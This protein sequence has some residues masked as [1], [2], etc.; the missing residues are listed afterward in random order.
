MIYLI[1]LN[2]FFSKVASKNITLEMSS[3]FDIDIDSQDENGVTMLME[4]IEFGEEQIV[5]E[6]L[7]EGANINLQNNYG[8]TALMFAIQKEQ[9]T[10][11]DSLIALGADV[12]HQDKNG[13]TPLMFAAYWGRTRCALIMMPQAKSCLVNIQGQTALMIAI[14]RRSVIIAKSLIFAGAKI[15]IQDNIGDTALMLAVETRQADIVKAIIDA[16]IDKDKSYLDIQ[17]NDGTTPLIA[18][19]NIRHIY[20]SDLLV[21]AGASSFIR[22]KE[23]YT[24]LNYASW[25]GQSFK[26]LFAKMLRTHTQNPKMPTK[27]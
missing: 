15:N 21:D 27:S 4:A 18:A 23:G 3:R 14:E 8:Q 11:V 2:D 25:N 13:C 12:N 24:A 1:I 16:N 7:Q 22:D 10:V 19:I 9:N 5:D 6:L 26:T 20:I 17:D